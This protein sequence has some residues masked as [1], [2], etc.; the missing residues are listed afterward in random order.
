MRENALL[1]SRHEDDGELEAL[2]RVHRDQRGGRL[3]VLVL[4][5]IGNEGDLFEE[6]RKLL[7]LRQR[8]V[9]L[10]E[11]AELLHVG[12]ALLPLLGPVL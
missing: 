2:D 3:G 9:V 10:G 5:D 11:R 1:H 7:V 4:I 8:D 6:A 12:P